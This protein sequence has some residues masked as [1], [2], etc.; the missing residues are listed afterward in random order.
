MKPPIHKIWKAE[1]RAIARAAKT[2][3]RAVLAEIKSLT[4]AA[5]KLNARKNQLI[6]GIDQRDAARDRRAAILQG[7]LNS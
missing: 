5:V 7:R 4:R 1:L 6:T 3:E 2:D